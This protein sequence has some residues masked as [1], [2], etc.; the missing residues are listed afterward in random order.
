MEF[1]LF[2]FIPFALSPGT[3]EMPNTPISLGLS[4]TRGNSLHNVAQEVVGHEGILLA[5]GQLG[6]HQDP[7]SLLSLVA[8]FASAVSLNFDENLV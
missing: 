5:P 6:V 3:T 1:P 4:H 8:F 2:Q 7:Q